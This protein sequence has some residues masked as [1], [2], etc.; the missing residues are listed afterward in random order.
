MLAEIDGVRQVIFFT[1]AG[2]VGVTPDE[3][4]VLW[5]FPWTTSFD[6]NIATP[7]VSGPYVFLS[8][9]YGKGC[10]LVK[11][12][13]TAAGFAANQVYKNTR[14]KAQFS[15]CVLFKD[16]LYGFDDTILTCMDFRTGHVDWTQRGFDKGSLTLADGHLFILSEFGIL[17]VVEATPEE[18][19]EK[20]RFTFAETKCWTVPVLANGRLYLRNEQKIACYDLKGAD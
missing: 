10:A 15:S 19:R 9:G 11:I 4:K 6:A 17:A 12:D 3:G 2:L 18:F 7:I 20:S 5:R 1:A 8:S 14:M 16:H 13:K